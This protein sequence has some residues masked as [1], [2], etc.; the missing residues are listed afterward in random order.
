MKEKSVQFTV[1]DA[2]KMDVGRQIVRL[3]SNKMEQLGLRTGDFVQL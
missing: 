3:S 1:A 2:E